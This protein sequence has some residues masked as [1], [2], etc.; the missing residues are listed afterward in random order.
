MITR[1]AILIIF[2]GLLLFASGCATTP[3]RGMIRGALSAQVVNIDGKNYIP[4]TLIAGYYQAKCE[5]DPVARRA[6]L[7]KE[8]RT[9]AFYVGMD[10]AAINGRPEKL[11]SPVVFYEGSVAIPADFA[12]EEISKVLSP[13]PI[14]EGPRPPVTQKYLIRKVV[15]DPGHGGNDPGAIGRT[16]LKEKDLVLDIGKRVKE[17]LNENGVDV[18]MTRDRDTF[19]PLEKRSKIANEGDVDFFVSIHANS[20]KLKGARGFEVYYL[21]TAVDDNARAVEAAENSFLKFDDS[22]FQRHNTDLEATLW[23][24]VYTENRQESVE[25]AKYIAK[26]VDGSTS[27]HNRGVKSARFYVLR[28]SQMPSVLVEVGF[29]SNPAEEKNLKDSAYRQAIATAITKGI[30]NY[31]SVY[32]SSD[33]FTK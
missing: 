26:A 31:K 13:P 14:A 16:G 4:L 32:E 6:D 25:L 3:R 20:A 33:G 17:Q 7:I 30:L 12:I 11:T 22:S 28:G 1:R 29:I 24:L 8:N 18:V 5:W 21:S 9:F 27:L 15:I 19:I 10:Y 23:D 2:A